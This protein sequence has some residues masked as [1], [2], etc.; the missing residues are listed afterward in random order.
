MDSPIGLLPRADALDLSGLDLPAGALDQLLTVD[1]DEWTR[2]AE[3]S[4]KDL[5]AFGESVPPALWREQEMLE[6]RLAG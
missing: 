3:A 4:A 2:E 6:A 5:R 1:R